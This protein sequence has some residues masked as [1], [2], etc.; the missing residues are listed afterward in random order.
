MLR[1]GHNALRSGIRGA[2]VVQAHLKATPSM[3]LYLCASLSVHRT[4]VLCAVLCASRGALPA[5]VCL[6]LAGCLIA[7]LTASSARIS[8]SLSGCSHLSVTSR[9][10][11]LVVRREGEPVD[12][13]LGTNS[14]E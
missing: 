9:C 6:Q 2:V 12:V 4:A 14:V 7:V 5:Y 10:E 1:E 3:T 13:A 11:V 8:I